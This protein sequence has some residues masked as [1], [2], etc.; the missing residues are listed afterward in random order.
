MMQRGNGRRQH[1]N[2]MS[3]QLP[4]VAF[5]PRET[6]VRLALRIDVAHQASRAA[7]SASLMA[8]RDV[9]KSRRVDGG[10]AGG[11]GYF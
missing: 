5:A 2:S 10:W 3:H 6:S 1:P 9:T 11:L 7:E 4:L 8:L